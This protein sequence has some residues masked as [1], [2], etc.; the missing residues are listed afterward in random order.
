MEIWK[1][2]RKFVKNENLKKKLKR[3]MEICKKKWKF[4]KKNENLKNKI[5]TWKKMNFEK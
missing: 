3:K 4:E 1:I 2:K 5:K